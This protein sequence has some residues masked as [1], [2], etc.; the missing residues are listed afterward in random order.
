MARLLFDAGRYCLQYKRPRCRVLILKTI[1]LLHE[2]K[3]WPV[4]GILF[5]KILVQ[6]NK[7]FSKNFGPWNISVNVSLCLLYM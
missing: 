3:V 2:N 4:T 5:W 1:M 7:N 6:R